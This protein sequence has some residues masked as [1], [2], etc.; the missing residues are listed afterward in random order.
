[1]VISSKIKLK[2]SGLNGNINFVLILVFK[3]NN[4]L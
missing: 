2:S 1:M 4:T 3:N